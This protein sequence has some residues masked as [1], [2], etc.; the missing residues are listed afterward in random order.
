MCKVNYLWSRSGPL[1]P[2]PYA[3]FSNLSETTYTGDG[4][5]RV[6]SNR[7]WHSRFIEFS[8]G[9]GGKVSNVGVFVES[10]TDK[11]TK[12]KIDSLREV[13]GGVVAVLVDLIGLEHETDEYGNILLASPNPENSDIVT[14][15]L[16]NKGETKQRRLMN[17]AGRKLLGRY[18]E[19]ALIK[20]IF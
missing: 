20:K 18:V 8:T 1:P 11:A 9:G 12:Q 6:V 13:A 14:P 7:I 2:G 19:N 16:L 15:P 5:L 17:D 4:A 3:L 10:A